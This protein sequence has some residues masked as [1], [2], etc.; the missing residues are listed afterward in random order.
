[1][2]ASRRVALV[3]G[4][5][6]RIGAHL[7]AVAAADGYHL[8]LHT[9]TRQ[10]ELARTAQRLRNSHG[11]TVTTHLVDLRSQAAVQN[12]VRQL[13]TDPP[14]LVVNN[15][16]HLPAPDHAHDWDAVRDALAIH[17][18]APNELAQALPCHGHI[19]NILDARLSLIDG[20]RTGYEVAKHTLATLTFLHARRLAP[21][22]RVNALAPGLIL[23]AHPGSTDLPTLARRRAPLQRP[24]TLEDLG[25]A[26][27]FLD[28]TSSVTGQ[29]V[30]V[31]SGEHLGPPTHG[32]A[33]LRDNV[34]APIP[35]E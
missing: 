18:L 32:Q 22:I 21:K 11:I 1:M 3:T 6:T 10:A 33:C 14:E 25:T 30:Y 12:W 7:A 34:N 20:T 4:A 24:A 35:R 15:A 29:I 23:P 26:L 19:V 28:R 5:A 17:A 27:L 31:D 9:G 13:R 16:S 2:T 8:H